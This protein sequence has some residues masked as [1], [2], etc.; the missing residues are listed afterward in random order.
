MCK[1]ITFYV[2]KRGN[3]NK[4]DSLSEGSFFSHIYT[5]DA[6]S[7][8]DRTFVFNALNCRYLRAFQETYTYSQSIVS[9]GTY[10]LSSQGSLFVH[11]LLSMLF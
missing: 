1:N 5:E 7:N 6:P 10:G 11:F 9:L 3:L 4:K 2:N 8:G